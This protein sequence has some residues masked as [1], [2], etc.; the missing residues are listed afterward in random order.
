MSIITISLFYP[1][2]ITISLFYPM[3]SF[4]QSIAWTA[5]LLYHRLKIA[6]LTCN[7][8]TL[9]S[10]IFCTEIIIKIATFFRTTLDYICKIVGVN[11]RNTKRIYNRA[12]TDSRFY[13][14][15]FYL[16]TKVDKNILNSN[17]TTSST[18]TSQLPSN[19][20]GWSIASSS[21]FDC[22]SIS[23]IPSSRNDTIAGT[24]TSVHMVNSQ[25]MSKI[26]HTQYFTSNTSHNIQ[27]K[28]VVYNNH[29]DVT[30][31]GT[32]YLK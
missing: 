3:T 28:A 29:D 6:A 31:R 7:R 16:C 1:C 21:K 30:F 5:V 4:K 17:V 23:I 27:F 11:G 10:T 20:K 13:E 14:I 8:H 2:I 18:D 19:P 32:D 24:S 15:E 22:S 25:S 12:L 26:N 9:R